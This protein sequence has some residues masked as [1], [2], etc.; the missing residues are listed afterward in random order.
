VVRDAIH[1]ATRNAHT[2]NAIVI[3]I[4]NAIVIVIA[5]AVVIANA[6]AADG[7]AAKNVAIDIRANAY[8]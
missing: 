7:S 3:V 4:A 8:T 5:N 6:I 1:G 2:E